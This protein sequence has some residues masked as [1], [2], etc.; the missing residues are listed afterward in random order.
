MYKRK[1]KHY[2]F[3]YQL[4]CIFSTVSTSRKTGD[5]LPDYRLIEIIP[6]FAIPRQTQRVVLRFKKQK[7]T[8]K[9]DFE[10]SAFE[11]KVIKQ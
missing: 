1:K 3:V 10:L 4:Y 9:Q 11:N 5:K 8:A 6:L 2:K 7:N